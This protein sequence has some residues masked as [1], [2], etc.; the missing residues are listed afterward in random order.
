MHWPAE[1]TRRVYSP[2]SKRSSEFS[3]NCYHSPSPIHELKRKI[4]G[5]RVH[6]LENLGEFESDDCKTEPNFPFLSFFCYFSQILTREPLRYQY[7]FSG[8][9]V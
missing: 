1:L 3:L 6:Y 8:L 4:S 2:L 9:I 7:I 5:T